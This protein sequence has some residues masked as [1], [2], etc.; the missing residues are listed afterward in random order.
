LRIYPYHSL[1]V[2]LTQLLR[3]P[4]MRDIMRNAWKQ[5][6]S[7]KCD[8]IMGAPAIQE[9][10][11]PDGETLFSVQLDG[12]IHLVFSL[13]IDWFNPFG[14]K[15]GGK[16]HSI[17]AIYMACL[18]LPPHLRYRPENIYLAGVIPGPREPTVFEI[19]SLI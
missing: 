2:W 6:T 17:G 5:N 10:K 18:N 15:Q 8:D 14:N 3:R 19:N 12:S 7:T 13:F 9:F 1:K 4:G 11:G 16:S